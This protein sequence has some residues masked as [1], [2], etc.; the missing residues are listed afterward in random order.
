VY[1]EQKA[2]QSLLLFA[3]APVHQNF[4]EIE[5]DEDVHDQ[6]T[7]PNVGGPAKNLKE[8][9]RQEGSGDAESHVFGP[10]LL[11]IE[12]DPLGGAKRGI[13]KER[14]TD[15]AQKLVIHKRSALENEVDETGFRTESE[16]MGKPR[17]GVGEIL[18][19]E[20]QSRNA[21]SNEEERLG[22]FEGGNQKQPLVVV[23]TICEELGWALNDSLKRAGDLWSQCPL[24]IR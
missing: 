20:A 2:K 15:P 18:M 11:E 6:E 14:K 24:S 3:S 9:P 12:A 7:E 16:M 5:E 13:G 8:L 1:G 10:G 19:N 4:Q 23:A 22:E 21:D 17:Q